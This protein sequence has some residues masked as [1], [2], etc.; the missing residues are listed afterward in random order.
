MFSESNIIQANYK[1]HSSVLET[2]I[3]RLSITSEDH[4][5]DENDFIGFLFKSSSAIDI[6]F[7]KLILGEF[8][9]DII[10]LG[11]TDGLFYYTASFEDVYPEESNFWHTISSPYQIKL[12]KII[13][14]NIGVLR[15]SLL[16]VQT[17][18][19]QKIGSV[20][21]TSDKLNNDDVN[22]L[23]DYLLGKNVSYWNPFALTVHQ[24]ENKPLRLSFF[25]LVAQLEKDINNI[26]L[27]L[28]EFLTNPISTL[29]P[30]Y[31]NEVFDERKIMDDYSIQWLF[32]NL[33]VLEK[34]NLISTNTVKIK[35]SVYNI[36]R[37][38]TKDFY[39]EVDIYEN[40]II[41]GFFIDL[42]DVL[43]AHLKNIR[44]KVDLLKEEEITLNKFSIV[45]IQ[46]KKFLERQGRLSK[47]L[48]NSIS[49]IKGTFSEYF[50][51]SFPLTEAPKP[52]N[53]FESKE[54]Y[55]IV[56]QIIIRWYDYKDLSWGSNEL[57]GGI[58]TLD[59]L[60][61]LFCLYK[62]ID[63]IKALGFKDPKSTLDNYHDY[64]NESNHIGI[65]DFGTSND[66]SNSVRLFYE[67]LPDELCTIIPTGTGRE[68]RPDFILEISNKHGVRY[69]ILDAKFKKIK[70][71]KRYTFQELIPKYLHGIGKIDGS[72]ISISGLIL[73]F[74]EDKSFI[75]KWKID[76]HKSTYSIE[77]NKSV[78][79]VILA[80]EV[81]LGK[82]RDIRLREILKRLILI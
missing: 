6:E 7:F 13:L 26:S 22:D 18:N 50:A 75:N 39:N 1:L 3:N 25:L 40:Q 73:L 69:V 9:F 42:I 78:S 44:L 46:E 35:N 15:I 63:V 16:N 36:K 38:L 47:E 5:I 17:N 77:G 45:K 37:M 28:P 70:N 61:E 27:L 66:N 21:V 60:Y 43:S 2:S 72:K 41:A 4:R 55:L 10:Y 51:I 74:P 34:T 67:K 79:P 48:I 68:L 71:I 8:E 12:G 33:D 81:P 56:H 57:F 62:L 80:I 20:E 58:R 11:E 82:H 24:N 49:I 23:F 53:K 32:S 31:I 65:Y 19:Y 54:H 52:V 29:N 14:N 76:F 30:T 59:K 64:L